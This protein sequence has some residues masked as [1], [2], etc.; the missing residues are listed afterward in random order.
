MEN[1]LDE[2]K[3][4]ILKDITIEQQMIDYLKQGSD[5]ILL[6]AISSKNETLIDIAIKNNFEDLLCCIIDTY[7]EVIKKKDEDHFTS[8]HLFAFYGLDKAWMYAVEKIPELIKIKD[9][10]GNTCLHQ[11]AYSGRSKGLR[12]ILKKHPKYA[13]LKNKEGRTVE[14]ILQT[15]WDVN[16]D[17]NLETVQSIIEESKRK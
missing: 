1:V 3:K 8:A 7:P 5:D 15:N 6:T 11:A 17:E 14:E 13:N 10:L 2:L 9:K 12:E 4:L 16:I